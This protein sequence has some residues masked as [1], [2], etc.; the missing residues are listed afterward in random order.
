MLRAV[1]CLPYLAVLL[2]DPAWTRG[3]RAAH[4]GTLPPL[5]PEA[6]EVKRVFRYQTREGRR[7][8]MNAEQRAAVLTYLDALLLELFHADCR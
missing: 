5:A 6:E 7:A 3:Q 2:A 8:V 1:D 4:D